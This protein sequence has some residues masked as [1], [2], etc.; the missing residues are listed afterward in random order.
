MKIFKYPLALQD[1]QVIYLPEGAPILTVQ[2][3]RN[4]LCLWV[5]VPDNIEEHPLQARAFNIYG[6]GHTLREKP[7]TYIGTAQTQDS[8]FVWH[9]FEETVI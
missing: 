1:R 6:T 5:G 9:V 2:E 8:T 3:Q 7:Q 4:E